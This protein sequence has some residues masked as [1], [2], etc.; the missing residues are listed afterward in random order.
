MPKRGEEGLE[1]L[2]KQTSSSSSSSSSNMWEGLDLKAIG[3][4][5]EAK[6]EELKA[7]KKR[8]GLFFRAKGLNLC[9]SPV[10]HGT[11]RLLNLPSLSVT[12]TDGSVSFALWYHAR[13][14][15]GKRVQLLSCS[16]VV[17]LVT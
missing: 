14:C 12:K 15:Q 7:R 8:Q 11:F 1:K 16:A 4:L 5:T 9:V 13:Y 3:I 2:E 17:V 10:Q 6:P